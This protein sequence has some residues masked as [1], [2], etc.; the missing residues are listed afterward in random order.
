MLA[1]GALVV[2]QGLAVVAEVLLRD[3]D[4]VEEVGG[5]MAGLRAQRRE[6]LLVALERAQVVAHQVAYGPAGDGGERGFAGVARG[7]VDGQGLVAGGQAL[8]VGSAALVQLR[9]HAQRP[10]FAAAIVG[11]ALAFQRPLIVVQG[12]R[13]LRAPEIG[14]TDPVVQLAAERGLGRQGLQEQRLQEPQRFRGLLAAAADSHQRVGPLEDG[15]DPLPVGLI[16]G[17]VLGRSSGLAGAR[18]CGS[19]EEPGGGGEHDHATSVEH[20]GP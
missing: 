17:G 18:W 16:G 6:R 13:V 4:L 2:A 8:E 11:R 3:G 14:R 7:P 15:V 10:R 9:D 1:E 20:V 12:L 19:A 5:I